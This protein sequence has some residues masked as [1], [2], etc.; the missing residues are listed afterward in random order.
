MHPKAR[1]M[2]SSPS[3]SVIVTASIWIRKV[4]KPRDWTP[5][6][7]GSDGMIFDNLT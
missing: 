1:S 5:G 4:A 2:D 6:D 3:E 7:I